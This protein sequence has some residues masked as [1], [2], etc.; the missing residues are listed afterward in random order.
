L[1]YNEVTERGVSILANALRNNIYLEE[2]NIS[3]NSIS[4]SGVYYLA[5]EVNSSVLKRVDLAQNDIS[6][7]GAANLA[8]MLATNTNLLELSLKRNRIGD[9]GMKL[10]A[11]VLVHSDTRLESLNLSANTDI[12]DESIDSI[13]NMMEHIQSLRKLDLRHN[14]LSRDGQQRLHDIAKSKRGFTLWLS[15]CI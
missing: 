11:D 13:V 4:D 7:Y 10:L 9:S 6:D 2:L 3:R 1:T 12:S 14:G 5:S 8:E 15:D